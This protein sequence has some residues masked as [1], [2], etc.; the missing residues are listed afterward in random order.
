M[1][2]HTDIEGGHEMRAGSRLREENKVDTP[3]PKSR[4]SVSQPVTHAGLL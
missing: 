2:R 4:K 1:H 3:E